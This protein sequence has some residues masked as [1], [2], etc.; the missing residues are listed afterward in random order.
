MRF[1]WAILCALPLAAADIA[2]A[3]QAL[4]FTYQ[5]NSQLIVSQAIVVA[6]PQSPTFTATR[7][8]ADTWLVLPSQNPA[9]L[10]ATAPLLLAVSVDPGLLSPKTYTSAITLRFAQGTITIPVTL[11]ITT[12]I[13]LA[14]SPAVLFFD[15]ADPF[16]NVGVGL[17][18]PTERFLVTPST[19]TPWLTVT[20]T[21]SPLTVVASSG[22]APPGVSVGAVQIR[23]SSV[24]VVANNPLS[25]PAVYLGASLASLGPLTVAPASLSFSA[26]GSQQVT[27]TGGA[28]TATSDSCWLTAA[29][30][31]STLTVSADP[32]G[33]APG[34]YQA[35]VTLASGG[36]LQLLPVTL[37]FDAAPTLSLAKIVNAASY[38]GPSVSPGEIVVL[39]GTGLGPAT[40]APLTLGPTGSVSTNVAC[41]KVLFNGVAAPIVY[42]SST[43]TAVAVPYDVDGAASA[44]VV[45][46]VNGQQSNA[47]TLPVV[48]AAP[49]IFTADAS[50]AGPG[51]ILN[52]DL[53][54]NSPSNPAA[55]GSI[56][57]IYMTGEGQTT[58]AG[59]NGRVT[60]TPPAPRQSVTA[61]VDGQPA[62][63]R[64]AGEA[65]GILSGVM[66]VNVLVPAGAR[67]GDLPVVITV[68]GVPTQNGV[69]V[70]VR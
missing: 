68:G 53:T 45:V 30:S 11:Q 54:V 48:A 52:S 5:Y 17:S 18:N 70:S 39:G 23:S 55:K 41:V 4:T 44:T 1:F 47:V 46:S 25:V 51:A 43:Q 7:P 26:A 21:S 38:A 27:V 29:V 57:A 50:G 3:P 40:L 10:T 22:K 28:F 59:V 32:V 37:T 56:V 8:A 64:F 9:S 69:T 34:T 35:A 62:E 19:T 31:G 6:S 12:A 66:Q 15:P 33:L 13:V 24:L 60:S 42:A 61:T 63:I 67:S 14:V 49:G 65:P 36:V 20:G 2:V 16:Q 58:P